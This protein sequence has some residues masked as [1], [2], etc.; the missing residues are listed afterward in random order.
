M[1]AW[2]HLASKLATA[3]KGDFERC[4]LPLLRMF[5]PSIIRTQ[6]QA[7]LDRA[8]IDLVVHVDNGPFPCVVQCKGFY[9]QEDIGRSQVKQIASSIESFIS[10]RFVCDNYLILHNRTGQNQEAV[11]EINL[12]LEKL[13]SSGKARVAEQWDRQEFLK[14]LK[15]RMLAVVAERTR[16]FSE[17]LV[18]QLNSAFTYG[19][20]VVPLVP[21]A[22]QTLSLRRNAT[23]EMSEKSEVR[24]RPISSILA[25]S[26]ERRW[27]LL[28]GPFGSGK[29]TAALH[30]AISEGR[31]VL[32]VRCQDISPPYSTSGT[33]LL[34]RK[35][36][37]S[38]NLFDDFNDEDRTQLERL[39]GPSL[40][41]LLTRADVD[42][43]LVL[44]GLDESRAFATPVAMAE[45][46]SALAEIR[47]P[48]V[49]TTRFEHLQSTFGDVSYFLATL[50]LKG[51]SKRLGGLLTLE[52]WGEQEILEFLQGAIDASAGE[53][54]EN[55]KRFRERVASSNLQGWEMEVCSHPLF[56]Q[57]MAEEVA[58]GT[59]FE[60]TYAGLLQR[61]SERKIRRDLT[62]NR[63]LPG[64]AI[65]ATSFVELM[66]D[67]MGRAAFL[68]T[69]IGDGKRALI[70]RLPAT[71]LQS[72]AETVFRTDHV[73]LSEL[74]CSSLIVP[75][76][77]RA[78][79]RPMHV[80][81]FLK[82]F[83]EFFLAWHFVS[84]GLDSTE[85]DELPMRFF[86]EL[87]AAEAADR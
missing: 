16:E 40:R 7:E 80:R 52:R 34:L 59:F 76:G 79:G 32:Y 64:K 31:T 2:P 27:M 30:A 58:L 82:V 38:L 11:V 70:E 46:S 77:F 44:D 39:A 8:G 19:A 9:S 15:K 60:G 5:W 83:H 45:L 10:S 55:L 24:R 42:A 13:L 26:S 84:K 6:G 53:E 49:F 23:V 69:E 25:N 73:T 41:V 75:V 43:V 36:V 50:S 28:V 17:V 4:V 78:F 62:V 81:F 68:M 29:S 33:N 54:R 85:L 12:V 72:E 20:V 47:C 14:R 22:E 86:R 65:D 74:V 35:I 63:A 18:R 3:T 56:L 21:V 66:F 1:T 51:G 37:E 71:I 48:V 87:A 67:L 57:L 61:W